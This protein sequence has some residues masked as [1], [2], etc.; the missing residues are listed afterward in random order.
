VNVVTID[1]TITRE[2]DI[3]PSGNERHQIILTE[4]ERFLGCIFFWQ[5]AEPIQIDLPS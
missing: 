4:D 5:G 2:A 1:I 3:F